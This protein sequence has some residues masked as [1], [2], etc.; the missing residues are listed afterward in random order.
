[1]SVLDTAEQILKELEEGQVKQASEGAEK[2][3]SSNESPSELCS[4]LRKCAGL[5]RDEQSA[6]VT[7][8][9]VKNFA[10]EVSA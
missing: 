2:T 5:I 9:D 6:E 8:Q 4:L 3:V 10:E 1:M 7:Y